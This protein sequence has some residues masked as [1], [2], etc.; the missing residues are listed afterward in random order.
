[1]Q[2]DTLIPDQ[3]NPR[4][5][6]RYAYVGNDPLN[7]NDPDGHCY[8]VCTVAVGAVLGAIVGVGLY[9]LNVSSSGQQ[10]DIGEAIVAGGVGALAGGLIGT[11]VAAA[12]TGALS[13]GAAAV[14]TSTGVGI[15]TS[16]GGY[17]L[18]NA[19]TGNKFN[20]NDFAINS[21]AGAASGA[22]GQAWASTVPKVMALN[23]GT[24]L[25]AYEASA[26]NHTG[27]LA[28]DEGA[29]WSI[30]MGVTS[31][32]ISGPYQAIDDLGQPLFRLGGNN[33]KN[34]LKI[35]A[36]KFPSLATSYWLKQSKVSFLRA[37][38]AGVTS[39]WPKPE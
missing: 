15:A 20:T 36:E 24:N 38:G 28:M 30:S 25:M 8:P 13:I 9:A 31:G 23:A 21:A 34:D 7:H 12:S 10:F 29:L 14:T 5:W 27:N 16:G 22:I 26:I 3:T 18:M 37:V 1:L 33:L 32:G 17:M 4:S 39:N 11:G 2:P 35:D 6:N 19:A